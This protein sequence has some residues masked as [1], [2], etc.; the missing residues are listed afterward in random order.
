MDKNRDILRRRIND[1]TFPHYHSSVM[2]F[3]PLEIEYIP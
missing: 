3:P 2:E 1:F